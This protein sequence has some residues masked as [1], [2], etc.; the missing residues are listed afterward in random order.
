[1]FLI[2]AHEVDETVELRRAAQHEETAFLLNATVFD[3]PLRPAGRRTREGRLVT[4]AIE[5]K[6]FRRFFFRMNRLLL[7]EGDGV[8]VVFA[9][10]SHQES[11]VPGDAHQHVLR[12]D[13]GQT[14]VVP[15][16]GHNARSIHCLSPTFTRI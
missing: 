16:G 7:P 12:L 9:A 10:F 8:G 5:T 3:L 15:P 11:S 13:T 1:M 2:V 4:T 6:R 14:G